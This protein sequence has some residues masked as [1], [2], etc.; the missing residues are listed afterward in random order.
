[1][2][3]AG[4][5][6]EFSRRGSEETQLSRLPRVVGRGA[7]CRAVNFGVRMPMSLVWTLGGLWHDM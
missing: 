6:S 4:G 1:M 5:D 2:T 3:T 7:E